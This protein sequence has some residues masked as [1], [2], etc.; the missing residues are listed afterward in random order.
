MLTLMVRHHFK[1]NLK[2]T[3]P[4]RKRQNAR[5]QPTGQ[6]IRSEKRLALYLRDEFHCVY[7]GRNLHKASPVD[8]TLDHLDCLSNGGQNHESNLVT[9]CRTCNCTRGDLGWTE[10]AT[11]KAAKK[12]RRLRKLD[13]GRYVELAKDL[14]AEKRW[15]R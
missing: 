6:W 1:G 15:T 5:F 11:R 14:S 7:C 10:Y 4:E 2:M 8:I 9:A 12:I 13:L 3:N